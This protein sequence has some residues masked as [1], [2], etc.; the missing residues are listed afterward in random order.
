MFLKLWYTLLSQLGCSGNQFS[1]CEG[2]IIYRIMIIYTHFC[3]NPV[4]FNYV[5]EDGRFFICWYN[6]QLSSVSLR[7]PSEV[8]IRRFRIR[9]TSVRRS[10]DSYTQELHRM[11]VINYEDEFFLSSATSSFGAVRTLTFHCAWWLHSP[12]ERPS[13]CLVVLFFNDSR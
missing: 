9:S 4:L 3:S 13:A 7:F 8:L 12:N 10:S 6:V 2:V 1:F 11:M 5:N